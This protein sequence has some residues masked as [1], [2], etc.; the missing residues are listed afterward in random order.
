MSSL[1]SA[2]N[3]YHKK[4]GAY[5]KELWEKSVDQRILRGVCAIP[6]RTT[7]IKTELIDV[8]LVRGS[9]FVKAKPQH[10]WIAATISG[11]KRVFFLPFFYSWWKLQTNA[12][13]SCILVI[14]YFLQI[15]ATFLYFSADEK[16]FPDVPVS[17]MLTPAAMTFILGIV[18]SQIVATFSSTKTRKNVTREKRRRLK[19]KRTKKPANYDRES[20]SSPDSASDDRQEILDVN[21]MRQTSNDNCDKKVV[22]SIDDYSCTQC[23]PCGCKKLYKSGQHLRF[24]FED[25]TKANSSNEESGVDDSNFVQP[26][27]NCIE[28]DDFKDSKTHIL[29]SSLLPTEIN[30]ENLQPNNCDIKSDNSISNP[31]TNNFSAENPT[32]YSKS[33]IIDI[34]SMYPQSSS[35][36]QIVNET[37]FFKESLNHCSVDRDDGNFS[38]DEDFFIARKSSGPR[39]QW[40][41]YSVGMKNSCNASKLCSKSHSLKHL[42]S[43]TSRR[44]SDGGV[45]YKKPKTYH[46]M[47]LSLQ[48]HRHS[49]D[50]ILIDDHVLSDGKE[51]TAVPLKDNPKISENSIPSFSLRNRKNE[52]QG[53]IPRILKLPINIKNFSSSCD[54]C[55]ETSP[56]TPSKPQTSDLEW[57][58]ITNTD[59]NSD[60][61][62]CSTQCSEGN[63]SDISPS[64]NP[65][66]WEIQ[67]PSKKPSNVGHTG[68][69]K[70][71]RPR[72]VS[73]TIWEHNEC[74]KADLTALDISSAIIQ[75]VDSSQHSS[76]YLYIGVFFAIVLSLLPLLFRLR[77]GVSTYI[78]QDVTTDVLTLSVPSS[79][80]VVKI[81]D[82]LLD[83]TLGSGWRVK[84]VTL[85]VLVERFTL[86]L[87]YFFLLSVAEKTFKQRFLY[88]KHFC[89]LTSSRR[90]KRSDLPHFRLN[91]VRNIKIWLS[92]RSYMKKLGPQ[93]SVDVIVSIA[94]ILEVCVVSFL[95]IQLLKETG[96]FAD[97][98]HCWELLFWTLSLGIFLLRFMV[99]GTK[100]NKKYRNLSVL[101][102]EQINLYLHMEQ[103][104]HKKE[105]L[106]LANNVL[107]LAADLLK[108]LESPFKISGL[109]ANSY[110][111][112]ITKVVVLSA[113]SAV[114]T[115]VL[116][117]KLKLYKIKIK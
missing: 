45:S 69:D 1:T 55:T 84:F 35:N 48:D 52:C 66:A 21:D 15:I 95:C 83:V 76:E 29:K 105:E 41:N 67:E 63:A 33:G 98:L 24:S 91:K 99:I 117:F 87:A 88:A 104:P 109:C 47:F 7:R 17:E 49:V 42:N 11:I 57:P 60:S 93:R 5:D 19:C 32:E 73:C 9:A 86:S 103:K 82:G 13:V 22:Q 100:I 56:N 62:D 12:L 92:I 50:N 18:H 90:A 79:E 38:S 37:S 77:N 31:L 85:I 28:V 40:T 4:I 46:A 8:D 20:K 26:P 3:W 74:K 58:L 39:E 16:E 44:Y 96:Q 43:I 70:G 116:G 78:I 25:N 81:T 51:S 54:S 6:K 97:K 36:V 14:L 53:N 114:L 34:S 10:S 94:F 89:Y 112:N 115:D 59:C 72:A 110:L 23:H 61:T 75:K 30:S 106:I 102:T 71:Y 2:L 80:E 65:F 108:E 107:K 101:I 64:E 27:E 68:S 111:Y 113:F